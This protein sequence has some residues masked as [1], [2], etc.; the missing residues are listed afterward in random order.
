VLFIRGKDRDNSV[1][2][3]RNLIR[4]YLSNPP[5]S[6][7]QNNTIRNTSYYTVSVCRMSRNGHT[8]SKEQLGAPITV[9]SAVFFSVQ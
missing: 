1:N 5:D 9:L 4:K 3:L 7:F 6:R 8:Q 2:I